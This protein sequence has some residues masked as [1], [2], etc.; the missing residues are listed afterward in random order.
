MEGKKII[1]IEKTVIIK[2]TK[3]VSI[4][5]RKLGTQFFLKVTSSSNKKLH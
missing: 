5:A 2:I 1:M 4:S 3:D